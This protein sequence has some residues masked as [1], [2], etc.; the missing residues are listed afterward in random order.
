MEPDFPVS[1]INLVS[2]VDWTDKC[3]VC[4]AIQKG[5]N[6]AMLK[7]RLERI[8]QDG[9]TSKIDVSLEINPDLPFNDSICV[10][11]GSDVCLTHMQPISFQPQRSS[12]LVTATMGPHE[13]PPG[14]KRG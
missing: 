12:K 5:W 2:D 6:L 4:I 9:K 1:I 11:Q 7:S 3:A 10:F 14:F 8:D 13:M